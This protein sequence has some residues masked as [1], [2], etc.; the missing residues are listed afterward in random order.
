MLTQTEGLRASVPCQGGTAIGL[1]SCFARSCSESFSR[2]EIES[3][4]SLTSRR[5]QKE[6]VL[7]LWLKGRRTRKRKLLLHSLLHLPLLLLLEALDARTEHC[8]GC[9]CL[10]GSRSTFCLAHPRP[11]GSRYRH[12]RPSAKHKKETHTNIEKKTRER[13]KEREMYRS[14]EDDVRTPVQQDSDG[15]GQEVK[16]LV[17]FLVQNHHL[18]S[19]TLAFLHQQQRP[20][21][22]IFHLRTD[23]YRQHRSKN[24][25]SISCR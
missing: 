19:P 4:C 3:C 15:G 6:V 14:L 8:L 1:S 18:H 22:L 21:N 13:E 17:P 2:W 5:K 10:A 24:H 12:C 9:T 25:G 23:S 20:E 16:V 7:D 11:K